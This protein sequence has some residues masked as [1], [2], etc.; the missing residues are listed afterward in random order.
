[1]AIDNGTVL[2]ITRNLPPVTGGMER[3]IAEAIRALANMAHVAVVGPA[4]A[5]ALLPPGVIHAGEFPLTPNA[6]SLLTGL[7]SSVRAARR[8]RPRL[9]IG[10]SGV[11]APMVLAA[12]RAAGCASAIFVHGLDLVYPSILYRYG[13]LPALRRIDRVIANSRHTCALAAT[14]GIRADRTA[15]IHPGV[16]MP[17]PIPTAAVEAFRNRHGLDGC[18]WLLSVGRL[19]P[20]KGLAPFIREV[21]PSLVH[22][23]P[24]VRLLI[25]GQRPDTALDPRHRAGVEDLKAVAIAAGIGNH[26]RLTGR[27]DDD[28]LA[29]A[30]AGA[31]AMVFPVLDLPGDVEGFGMVALEAAAHGVPTFGFAVGGVVDAVADGISGR[32]VQA[33]DYPALGAAL[34]SHLRTPTVSTDD[35][36]AFAAGLAWPRFHENLRRLIQHSSVLAPT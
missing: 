17:A 11:C 18:R 33:G 21:L 7:V 4:A 28:E 32:L 31:T 6:S 1:M 10:G 30:Y 26:V 16:E 29:L 2:V 9:V 3:L 13:F 15:L 36:R 12:A 20:R 22:D 23:H 19:T 25:V 8:L 14:A 5:E 34:E 27:L 35:C 24:D